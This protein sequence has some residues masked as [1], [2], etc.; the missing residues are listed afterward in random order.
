[1]IDGLTELQFARLVEKQADDQEAE[2][3]TRKRERK[4]RILANRAARKLLGQD[5]NGGEEEEEEDGDDAEAVQQEED[6]E[7]AQK[8]QRTTLKLHANR[9]DDPSR[10][11]FNEDEDDESPSSKHRRIE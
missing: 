10:S 9:P 2:R 3:S 5:G 7:V 11:S 8:P 1:M 6:T 4:E